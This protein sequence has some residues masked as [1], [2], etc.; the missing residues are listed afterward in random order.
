MFLVIDNGFR[1]SST[2]M[3]PS[4]EYL[5]P[6]NAEMPSSMPV[7][8][9]EHNPTISSV[10]SGMGEAHSSEASK[11]ELGPT[12]ISASNCNAVSKIYDS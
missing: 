2:S 3:D 7:T 4:S 5:L 8:M 6:L 12:P 10:F 1:L 11:M 9:H